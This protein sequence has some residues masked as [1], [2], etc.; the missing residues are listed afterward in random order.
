M[1][2]ITQTS[3]VTKTLSFYKEAGIWYADLPAFLEANL[4]TKANLMMVEG[5]DTFLDLVSNNQGIATL[6]LSTE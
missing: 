5:A 3:T 2:T 4:G 6:K 1:P